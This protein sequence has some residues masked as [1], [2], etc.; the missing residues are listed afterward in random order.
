MKHV[1][2]KK[3]SVKVFYLV[4]LGFALFH[5]QTVWINPP[6]ALSRRMELA[7]AVGLLL[8]ALGF[9]L[10]GFAAYVAISEDTIETA[11][12]SASNQCSSTR[13]TI[14]ASTTSTK[15]SATSV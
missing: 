5:A 1:Y 11:A 12:S 14:V 10:Y 15:T 8:P 2:G 3:T 9:V 7:I 13:S 4:S 6:E